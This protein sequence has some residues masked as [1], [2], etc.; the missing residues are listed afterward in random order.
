MTPEHTPRPGHTWNTTV[1]P[2]EQPV[3]DEQ[4][5]PRPNRAARRAL[6]RRRRSMGRTDL[7]DIANYP[8]TPR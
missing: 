8:T 7:P 5:E 2:V 1:R 3:T 4:P 6:A